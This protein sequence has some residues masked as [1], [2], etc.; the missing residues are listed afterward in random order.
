MSIDFHNKLKLIEKTAAE[1][2]IIVIINNIATLSV[3]YM[4]P[5]GLEFLGVTLEELKEMGED[6]NRRY[7]NPEDTADYIPKILSLMESAD[8]NQVISFFQQVRS[9]EKSPWSWHFTTLKIF[10]SDENGKPT[11]LISNAFPVDPL[12]HITHKVNRLLE[13]NDRM[14][15]EYPVFASLTKREKEII[16]HLAKGK[17]APAIAELLFV[18]TSTIEQ[19]R[20]NIKKKTGLKNLPELIRFAQ[21]FD[22]V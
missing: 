3:E 17:S 12:Y 7:F 13:E 6:Y 4:S 19:H 20:K 2:P 22:I 5:R 15:K 8:E 14:R 18:S 1:L 9:S 10:F 11:H 21:A 16:H